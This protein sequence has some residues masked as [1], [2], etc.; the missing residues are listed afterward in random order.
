RAFTRHRPPV[1]PPPTTIEQPAVKTKKVSGWWIAVALIV[2][3][4]TGFSLISMYV[5]KTPA[6]SKGA[7]L[8]NTKPVTRSIPN[9][10][11][12]TYDVKTNPGDSVFIQQSWD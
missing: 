6:A 8:F 11:I 1:I 5:K 10:V 3:A 2:I 7:V 4:V 9:S 12:F